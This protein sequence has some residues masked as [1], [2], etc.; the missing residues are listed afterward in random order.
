MGMFGKK[1]ESPDVAPPPKTDMP[2][3]PSSGQPDIPPLPRP[4]DAPGIPEPTAPMGTGMTPQPGPQGMPGLS[5]PE[6]AGPSG[7]PPSPS[8]LPG[9]QGIPNLDIPEM[10]PMEDLDLPPPPAYPGG[11]GAEPAPMDAGDSL[12][13]SDPMGLPVEPDMPEEKL[14]IKPRVHHVPRREGPTKQQAIAEVEK[15]PEPRGPIYVPVE[16]YKAV[17]DGTEQVRGDLKEAT[18]V[19]GRLNELKNEE[20]K[21]FEKWRSELEDIQRKLTYVDKIIFESS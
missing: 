15:R 3:P 16:D 2:P 18:E 9:D 21:E 1:Q 14:E 8:A 4:G 12:M 7:L 5:G 11:G 19:L 20:D 6:P 17:L 10:P 13:S